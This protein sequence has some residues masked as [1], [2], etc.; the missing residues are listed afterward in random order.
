MKEQMETIQPIINGSV[1]PNLTQELFN[2]LPF[3]TKKSV[4]WNIMVSIGFAHSFPGVDPRCY[5]KL[6]EKFEYSSIIEEDANDLF[7][8]MRER[9]KASHNRMLGKTKDLYYELGKKIHAAQKELGFGGYVQ[10]DAY[11]LKGYID[12]GGSWNDFNSSNVGAAV[13]RMDSLAPCRD[14]GVNNPNSGHPMHQWKVVHSCEYVI[15]SYEFI[16]K[17]D[18]EKVQA[19]YIEHWEAKG[20]SIKA[21]SVRIEINELDG[22]YYTVELIWWWD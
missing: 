20:R 5:E 12:A 17:K 19:F 14:Y 2:E 22:N 9:Y 13:S 8:T 11:R 10:L 6:E 3:D 18:L 21:D 16:D 4:I 1:N 15:L 7:A